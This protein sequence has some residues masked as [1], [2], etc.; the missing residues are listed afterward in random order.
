MAKKFT[1]H[2]ALA[3]KTFCITYLKNT[4]IYLKNDN[5]SVYKLLH[6]HPCRLGL[7]PFVT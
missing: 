6:Y 3:T 1:T 5:R 2:K 4:K 7:R